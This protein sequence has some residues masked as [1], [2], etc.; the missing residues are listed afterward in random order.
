MIVV[1]VHQIE[2]KPEVWWK[3]LEITTK[4]YGESKSLGI[5]TFQY[6]TTTGNIRRG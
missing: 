5:G 1:E 4:K 6:Q 3:Q 2:W